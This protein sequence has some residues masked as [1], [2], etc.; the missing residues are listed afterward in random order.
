MSLIL[1]L[2]SAGGRKLEDVEHILEKC[3]DLVQAVNPDK[4]CELMT[5]TFN[6]I[7]V[8]LPIFV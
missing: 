7:T 4:H 8:I 2:F 6:A 5:E 3:S 1:I